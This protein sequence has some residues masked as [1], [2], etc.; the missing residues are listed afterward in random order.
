[1]PV[2]SVRMQCLIG[3]WQAEGS[4]LLN[5]SPRCHLAIAICLFA[6]LVQACG[7]ATRELEQVNAQ[8]ANTETA[9][10]AALI[11][12]QSV[13]AASIRVSIDGD[14][15]VL[16]GFVGTKTEFDTAERLA[17]QNVQ[18]LPVINLLEIR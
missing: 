1:M 8:Q 16:S 3:Y 5:R 15:I 10:K 17:R 13:N 7:V 6:L 11:N 14:S 18:R 12:E 9:V 4:I 2:N